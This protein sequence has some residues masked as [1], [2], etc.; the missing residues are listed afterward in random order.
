MESITNILDRSAFRLADKRVRKLALCCP[1]RFLDKPFDRH[2]SKYPE[3]CHDQ[4]YNKVTYLVS[5]VVQKKMEAAGLIRVDL[6]PAKLHQPRPIRAYV[7]ISSDHNPS[8]K[9]LI[10]IQHLDNLQPGVWN[11]S[12]LMLHS[13]TRDSMLAYIEAAVNSDFNVL[14]M[15]PNERRRY[16][17]E[18][19]RYVEQFETIEDHATRIWEHVINSGKYKEVAIVAHGDG[20]R[21]VFRMINPLKV[22]TMKI[23][24]AFI[25]SHRLFVGDSPWPLFQYIA[26]RFD[27][28]C[29]NVV[30]NCHVLGSENQT[31]LPS[32]AMAKVFKYLGIKMPVT[33]DCGKGD[34]LKAF[35]VGITRKHFTNQ[36]HQHFVKGIFIL[37][38]FDS[39]RTV[40]YENSTHTAI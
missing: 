23:K 32:L 8:G 28:K 2:D 14:V 35:G 39:Q 36:P 7:Y 31:L 4:R 12:A 24:I 3:H 11:R 34:S 6:W 17:A 30:V 15:N 38:Q 18:D 25:D 5:K 10:L 37:I 20:G 16:H 27:Q 40:K 9:L 33:K 29:P 13:I 26:R 19:G 21:C 1:P 22:Y